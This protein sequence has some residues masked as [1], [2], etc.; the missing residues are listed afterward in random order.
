MRTINLSLHSSSLPALAA[1]LLMSGLAAPAAATDDLVTEE[2]LPLR[3]CRLP[4]ET[5]R[6][7]W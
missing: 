6:R 7:L 4:M 3:N 1:A 2:D 5:R